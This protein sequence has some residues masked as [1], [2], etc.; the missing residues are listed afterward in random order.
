MA[1]GRVHFP[2]LGIDLASITPRH[3]LR[4]R[5]GLLRGPCRQIL[6]RAI[7]TRAGR[8]RCR[9]RAA[10]S[11][12]AAAQGRSRGL[13]VAVRRDRRHAGD[14]ALLQG[15]TASA[16]LRSS[17]CA[18]RRS[19]A[20][21]TSCL[22]TLAGPEIGVASTKA[23]TCQL[24]TL[25]CLALAVAPC[26]RRDRSPRRSGTWSRALTEVPRHISSH[27]A[28]RAPAIEEMAHWLSKGARCAL[29]RPRRQL[30]DCARR[31]A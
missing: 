29:P 3:H 5:H 16:S 26:T 21:A 28:R 25:A 15:A 23:F 9:L 10:L 6:A 7:C 4:L 2:D 14:V 17:T 12:G 20:R 1:A 22:P 24:S 30:S 8:D 19:R 11:R 13:R 27:S 18:R 31:C